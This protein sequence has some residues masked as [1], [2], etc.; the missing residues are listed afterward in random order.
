MRHL[1]LPPEIDALL[2][3][4]RPETGFPELAADLVVGRYVAGHLITVSRK[5]APDVDL[6]KLEGLDEIWTLCF[7]R[8]RPGWRII[9]RF[10]E[11]DLF[12]GLRAYDRHDLGTRFSYSG[13]GVGIIGDWEE[14]FG[15]I[16]PLR[17][18]DLNDY[19]S[20]VFRDVDAK[21]E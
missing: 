12:V 9:G 21:E 2:D 6:K 3:G 8:P 17:S 18:N 13:K 4:K 14:Y 19:L 11:R 5:P 1:M 20:G 7:R 16:Q 15:G 10:L